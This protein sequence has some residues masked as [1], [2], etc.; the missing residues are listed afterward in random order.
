MTASTTL[1]RTQPEV[2]QPATRIAVTPRQDS[3]AAG[4]VAK[5]AEAELREPGED[6][7]RGDVERHQEPG[8]HQAE[9]RRPRP[10]PPLRQRMGA[11]QREQDLEE[12]DAEA[13][14]EP[15]PQE[16]PQRHPL[17]GADVVVPAQRLGQ[18]PDGGREDLGLR[19]QGKQNHPPERHQHQRR[20][21]DECGQK[22]DPPR[23]EP[24]HR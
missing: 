21:G 11:G 9:D 13:D 7:D 2:V 17:E 3:Q 10:D 14:D 16:P 15:V 24:R 12:Q 23:A 19:L 20:P 5:K 18:E 4:S 1:A 6:R 22:H 8:Q